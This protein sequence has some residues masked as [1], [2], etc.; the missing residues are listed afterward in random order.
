M[1]PHWIVGYGGPVEVLVI[2]DRLGEQAHLSSD[3]PSR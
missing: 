1:T 2:F 3:D